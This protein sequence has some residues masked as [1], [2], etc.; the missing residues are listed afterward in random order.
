MK[1][2]LTIIHLGKYHWL[3]LQFPVTH[4]AS[5][6]II[7]SLFEACMRCTCA[8]CALSSYHLQLG[9]DEQTNANRQLKAT[10]TLTAMKLSLEK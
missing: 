2:S 5:E 6:A 10:M 4:Q 1:N 9:R 3:I 7:M 8:C